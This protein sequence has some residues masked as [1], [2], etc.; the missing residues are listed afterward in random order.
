MEKHYDIFISGPAEKYC[1]VKYKTL[2][3]QAFPRA[4]IYDTEETH[5][6][7]W[8][9][10]DLIALGQAKFMVVLV[11]DFPMPGM[12]PKTGFFYA[13]FAERQ[14]DFFKASVNPN[15]IFIWPDNVKPDYGKK[16]AARM[17]LI[18]STAEEAINFLRTLADCHCW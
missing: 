7:D 14:G 8:F 18:V 15:L 4:S 12:S 16:V 9:T 11:P 2:I 1:N 17:G 6:G 10:N 5:D 3:R 13:K